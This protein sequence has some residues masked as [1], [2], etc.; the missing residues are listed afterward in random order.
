[1][2]YT[3]LADWFCKTEVG[4]V[5]CAVRTESLYKQIRLALKGMMIIIIITTTTIIIIIKRKTKKLG[6]G[7]S[8]F[9]VLERDA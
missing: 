8:T 3:T 4:S 1:L 5:Y 7:V 9:R 6:I 2:P